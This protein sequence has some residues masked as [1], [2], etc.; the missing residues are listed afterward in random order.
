MDDILTDYWTAY[1]SFPLLQAHKVKP[2]INMLIFADINLLA[3]V[4]LIGIM[5]L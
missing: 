4:N 3:K 2:F 5:S 1:T